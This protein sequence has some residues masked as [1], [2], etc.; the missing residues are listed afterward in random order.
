MVDQ[1][2]LITLGTVGLMKHGD[3]LDI[4]VFSRLYRLHEIDGSVARALHKRDGSFGT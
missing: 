4:L 1:R 3:R 2:S